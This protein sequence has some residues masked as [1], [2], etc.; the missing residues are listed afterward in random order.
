MS[1]LHEGPCCFL[2][3]VPECWEMLQKSGAGHGCPLAPVACLGKA[4]NPAW[5]ALLPIGSHHMYSV[6]LSASSLT[7]NSLLSLCQDATAAVIELLHVHL[8]CPLLA[9]HMLQ[10]PS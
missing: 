1:C 7:L 6:F 3:E 2:K 5:V 10:G 4:H 8:S 9:F